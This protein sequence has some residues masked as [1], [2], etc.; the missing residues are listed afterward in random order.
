MTSRSN[1]AHSS[2]LMGDAF[3]CFKSGV[4]ET[5]VGFGDPSGLSLAGEVISGAGRDRFRVS[6]STLLLLSS[7]SA[8]RF[9]LP[10]VIIVA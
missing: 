6:S 7:S 10:L 2:S 1:A 5:A 4:G 3:G 8:L 9:L